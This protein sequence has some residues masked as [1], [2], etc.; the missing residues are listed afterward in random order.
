MSS[1][2]CWHFGPS[3]VGCRTVVSAY[4]HAPGGNSGVTTVEY[5]IG[6]TGKHG[7]SNTDAHTHTHTLAPRPKKSLLRLRPLDDDL[8]SLLPLLLSNHSAANRPATGNKGRHHLGIL[9]NNKPTD[10]MTATRR[11]ANNL[12]NACRRLFR[13]SR[14]VSQQCSLEKKKSGPNQTC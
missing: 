12:R 4:D 2:V 1:R 10:T 7:A 8:M 11:R 14:V 3:S 13:T 6:Q 9:H 5:L